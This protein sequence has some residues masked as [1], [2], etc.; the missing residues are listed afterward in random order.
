M[1]NCPVTSCY[2]FFRNNSHLWEA[3][4]NKRNSIKTWGLHHCIKHGKLLILVI[5]FLKISKDYMEMDSKQD[6]WQ[7]HFPIDLLEYNGYLRIALIH[8][9][10]AIK[11]CG[12]HHCME[13]AKPLIL[14]IL[15]LKICPGYV[16]LGYKT[17]RLTTAFFSRFSWI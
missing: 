7:V 6:D 12:F 8:E 9:W 1:L 2:A 4:I 5:L 15:F 17:E 11:T 14:V 3:L 16:E 13:Q 10:N